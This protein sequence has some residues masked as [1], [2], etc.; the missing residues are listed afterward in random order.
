MLLLSMPSIH[1]VSFAIVM[2]DGQP[3]C[4]NVVTFLDIQ[5]IRPG[6]SGDVLVGGIAVTGMIKAPSTTAS[7]LKTSLSTNHGY[8]Q[9]FDLR[10]EMHHTS[11]A[12]F[13]LLCLLGLD[14]SPVASA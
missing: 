13:S 6:I 11:P 2:R 7:T 8:K 9:A 4:L 14:G 3:I 10:S 5:P 1:T 12:L